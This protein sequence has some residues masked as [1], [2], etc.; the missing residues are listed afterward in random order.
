MISMPEMYLFNYYK[1]R[2][3][4]EDYWTL[5]PEAYTSGY[6]PH[7]TEAMSNGSYRE[8]YIQ[9]TR[10]GVRTVVSLIPDIEY[11][12]GTGSMEDPYIVD[13]PPTGE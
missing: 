5:T 1:T 4:G 12:S 11:L 8:N 9:N 10:Y 13:A 2:K 3:T 7:I 6:G